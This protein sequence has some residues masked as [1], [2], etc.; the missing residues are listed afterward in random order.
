MSTDNVAVAV[1]V[2]QAVTSNTTN[3]VSYKETINEPIISGAQGPQ[4]IKGDVGSASVD[5][6]SDVDV[7]GLVNG[8]LLIYNNQL[9]LWK[10][11]KTLEQQTLECGQY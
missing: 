5:T 1:N 6:L 7:T 4:G 10:V 11:S 9:G 2:I 3:I 8:A